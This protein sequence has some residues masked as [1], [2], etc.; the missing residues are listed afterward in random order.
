[1]KNAIVTGT[2]TGIGL[3][4]SLH[5]A[6]N[7]YRVFATMRNL[8][9]SDAIKEA[10]GKEDLAVEVIEMDVCDDASV[11]RG[12]QE[13]VSKGGPIDL[14]VNNAGIGGAAPFEI[15]PLEEHRK[16]FETNYFGVVRCIQQVLPSM[17]ERESGCIVNITS[18]VGL[19]ATPNQIPYSASK[20]AVESLGEALAH[21]VQSFGIRVVNVEPGV[22]MTNIFENSAE[23]THYD[24][25]SPYAHIMQHNGRVFGAG[26]E[27]NV[28]PILVAE[29]ILEAITTENY[30]LRWPVGPD[31]DGM[32]AV[33][34]QEGLSEKWISLG[35]IKDK[36]EYADEFEK[37]FGF[38]IVNEKK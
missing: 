19:Q 30:K 4:T 10:A 35:A 25:T 21:E 34:N 20:W 27:R 28:Q 14:L 26:F 24:K 31:A 5:L 7:G 17:R 22:I 32:A 33:R 18:V 36:Y 37:L 11:E 8:A 6:R 2:S 16:M 9:K 23:Q 15:T 3:V 1:M 29:T 12:F 38:R 13:V